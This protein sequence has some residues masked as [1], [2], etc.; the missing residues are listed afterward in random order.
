MSV[1]NLIGG[2]MDET[3]A[4]QVAKRR[5][6]QMK[7]RLT[8]IMSTVALVGTGLM[9]TA[10]AS[11]AVDFGGNY[12]SA[13]VDYTKPSTLATGDYDFDTAVDDRRLYQSMDT[14]FTIVPTLSVPGKTT[15]LYNGIQIANFNSVANPGVNVYRLS[16]GASLDFLTVS[17][18]AGTA[19]MGLVITPT[20][21]KADF[22]TGLNA[23]S[24]LSFSN[25]ANSVSFNVTLATGMNTARVLVKN[26]S[27]WYVSASQG[28]AAG[29]VSLNGYT[30][31]WYAYDPSNNLFLNTAALGTSVAGSTLTD[32]QSVGVLMQGMF[33]GTAANAANFQINRISADL[34]VI[35]EPATIGML[36]LGAISIL[37]CRRF[38]A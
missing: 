13:N 12:V 8:M 16:N 17:S 37:I 15:Q 29:A 9:S 22:L 21:K 26:G 32:I 7:K 33:N 5:R 28:A 4:M 6:N 25:S 30:E 35:P 14:A 31:N 27:S 38:R 34:T 18:L 19:N 24:N 10:W 36:G 11:L 1:F 2:C 20:V 23:L 3:N